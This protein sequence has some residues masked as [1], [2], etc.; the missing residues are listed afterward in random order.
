MKKKAQGWKVEK[1]RPND[2]KA[3]RRL[4]E[5]SE[6]PAD[7]LEDAE[8]WCVRDSA[9]RVLGAA[10]LETW[11]R[12]GLLRSVV[13]DGKLRGSGVGRA[14]VERILEEGSAKDLAELYLI[15]ETAPPFFEKFGFRPVERKKV[16]GDVL[17]SME[18]KEA[19]PDTA[20]VM[21]LRLR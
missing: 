4:I 10:G 19:C 20:T 8:L 11:G 2:L 3:L 15:T 13:V 6:L 21:R 18:F 5:A 1:A 14:L 7:G 16:K 17:N 12:Q 9:S